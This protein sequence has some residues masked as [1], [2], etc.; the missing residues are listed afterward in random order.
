MP[1]PR[2]T[3]TPARTGLTLGLAAALA[4]IVVIATGTEKADTPERAATSDTTEATVLGNVIE[5]PETTTTD[6]E[7]GTT[8]APTTTEPPT[9]TGPPTTAELPNT[10][11]T[12]APPP[13]P[14][15]AA[16][17]T[18]P[19]A[20]APPAT[21]PP[22]TAPPAAA[23]ATVTLDIAGGADFESIV[24]RMAREGGGGGQI[25]VPPGGSQAIFDDVP[26]G[27]WELFLE[28]STRRTGPDSQG[29]QLQSQGI[30]R[31]GPF[32]LDPGGNLYGTWSRENGWTLA[33]PG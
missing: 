33:L 13:P 22:A 30:D 31:S 26:P 16:P 18:A 19:P 20:T 4:L 28:Y 24:V 6:P 2:P 8:E 15:T 23:P 21:A 7:R 27:D 10:V 29:N 32:R 9:T 12:T 1:L 14:A 25:D 11:P 17:T 5:R 3:S